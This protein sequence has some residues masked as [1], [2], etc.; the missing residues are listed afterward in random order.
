MLTDSTVQ[1]DISAIF[2]TNIIFRTNVCFLK[3][4]YNFVRFL[5]IILMKIL[6]LENASCGF[7]VN[8]EQ[9]HKEFF[10]VMLKV[11]DILCFVSLSLI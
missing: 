11:F 2:R 1:F 4:V 5:F 10:T 6:P 9:D 3:F 7:K 8:Y